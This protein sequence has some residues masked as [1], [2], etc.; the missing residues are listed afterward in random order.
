MNTKILLALFLS[1]AVVGGIGSQ[2]TAQEVLEIEPEVPLVTPDPGVDPDDD[3]DVD[4]DD[5]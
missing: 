2:A 5:D 1:F 3:L 4:D